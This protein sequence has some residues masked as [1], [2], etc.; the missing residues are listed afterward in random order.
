M[1]RRIFV[2]LTSALTLL[3]FALANTVFQPALAGWRTDLSE[4]R[5][6][7]LSEGTKSTLETLAEPVELTFVYSRRV[8]QEYPAVRSYADRVRELLRAFKSVGG[9]NIRL[10]ESD[11]APFSEDE[12]EALA[13]GIT[14]IRTDG[15]DPL[16]FGLIGRNTVDDE[17]VIP[18]LAPEREATLEYDL[19]RLIARLDDPE[20]ATVGIITDLQNF[21]GDGQENGYYALQEIARSY[22]IQPIGVT[23]A[24]IP[25]DV[26]VLLLAHAANLSEYQQYLIDQFI[27]DKGRALIFVDP[28][29]KAA[30][31]GGEIG[32]DGAARSDLGALSDAWGIEL[33]D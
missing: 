28:A 11:P 25:D 6:F 10:I 22:R 21:K 20:P 7:S 17:L 15:N 13:F 18:F 8:G 33:S 30:A 32:T 19:T 29:S 31:V 5:Q 2:W 4:G 12:D 14:A 3:V 23:F 1:T 24:S 9:R 27:L 16:Y 26:D